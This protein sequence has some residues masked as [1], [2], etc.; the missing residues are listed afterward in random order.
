MYLQGFALKPNNNAKAIII[1]SLL[2]GV[3][4]HRTVNAENA[5]KKIMV[6]QLPTLSA[7]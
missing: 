3:H 1:P 7:T 5:V 2:A 4:K 6:F